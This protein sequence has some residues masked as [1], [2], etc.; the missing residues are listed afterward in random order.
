MHFILMKRNLTCIYL[1][2]Q[3]FFL[4]IHKHKHDT[5]VNNLSK[6]KAKVYT[7]QKTFI[8]IVSSGAEQEKIDIWNFFFL[9]LNADFVLDGSWIFEKFCTSKRNGTYMG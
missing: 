4:K 6:S 9:F 1:T 2:N 3:L 8:V 7:S 5:K